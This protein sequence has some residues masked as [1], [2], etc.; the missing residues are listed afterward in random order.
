M[1]GEHHCL[2]FN[3]QKVTI[4][5]CACRRNVER[6]SSKAIFPD[7]ILVAEYAER[8]FLA[9]FGFGA[10]FYHTFLDYKHCICRFTLSEDNLFLPKGHNL[11]A[12]TDGGKE[13]FTVEITSCFRSHINGQCSALHFILARRRM[14]QKDELSHTQ[15]N[16]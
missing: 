11:S 9:C 3:P 15:R 13:D 10:E 6:Q 14:L 16:A 8:C 2:L 1:K 12:I 4:G 5:Y 7:K